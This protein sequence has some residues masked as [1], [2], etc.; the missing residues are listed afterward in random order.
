MSLHQIEDFISVCFHFAHTTM[1]RLLKHALAWQGIDANVIRLHLGI[2][3]IF[4]GRHDDGM[5]DMIEVF[6]NKGERVFLSILRDIPLPERAR[7]S[8]SSHQ[9]GI[10]LLQSNRTEANVRLAVKCFSIAI[11]FCRETDLVLEGQYGSYTNRLIIVEFN[12]LLEK[13][14][15]DNPF[16]LWLLLTEAKCLRGIRKKSDTPN[17]SARSVLPKSL[18]ANFRFHPKT[19]FQLQKLKRKLLLP[20]HSAVRS[21]LYSTSQCCEIASNYFTFCCGALI[22]LSCCLTSLTF[23]F[24]YLM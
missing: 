18:K 6:T 19:F 2:M 15:A 12:C 24:G 5:N 4:T 14:C 23:S 1:F 21:L 7:L 16:K 22:I 17:R 8:E 11:L 3:K 9:Y 10:G 13:I 20:L